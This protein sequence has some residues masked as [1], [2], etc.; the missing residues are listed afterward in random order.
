[1]NLAIG[2]LEYYLFFFK[3][4]FM[5]QGAPDDAWKCFYGRRG[6]SPRMAYCFR[7]AARRRVYL[8][9]YFSEQAT[10]L[11]LISDFGY[12]VIQ[13]FGLLDQNLTVHW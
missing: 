9:L 12:G 2:F 5:R 8:A 10:S 3:Q 11:G 6:V 1:L 7:N 13:N 4:S